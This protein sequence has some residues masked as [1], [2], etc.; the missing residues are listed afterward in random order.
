MVIKPSV[1]HICTALLVAI[2]L[3]GLSAARP[4]AAAE[5]VSG[6]DKLEE[7]IVTANKR[8][9]KAFEVANSITALSSEKLGLLPDFRNFAPLVPGLQLQ[10]ISASRNRLILRGL[11]AGGSGAVVATVIDE[12]PLS[13]STGNAAG[14]VTTTNPLTYDMQRIEVLRG[15]QGTIYG[16]SSEGGLIKYVTNKPELGGWQGGFELGGVSVSGGQTAGSIKGFINLPLG[17]TFALRIT[18]FTEDLPG[19]IDN[20]L[21]GEK[22]MNRGSRK[23]G[24]IGALWQ[25][26][27]NLAISAQVAKQDLEVGASN[28]VALVGAQTQLNAGQAQPTNR[29]D[30]KRGVAYDSAL[31]ERESSPMTY[32]YLQIDYD[33]PFAKITSV[34]SKGTLTLDSRDDF[35][36]RQIRPGIPQYRFFGPG[37]PAPIYRVPLVSDARNEIKLTKK[38]QELRV[39]S[40]P[41]SK[42]GGLDLDWQIGGMVTDEF[43]DWTQSAGFYSAAD[44]NGPELVPPGGNAELD[45]PN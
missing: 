27:E 22:D 13:F 24:R 28:A 10:Q 11:N 1:S 44:P 45:A 21:D 38:T 23:G 34:T 20:I 18:G 3:L 7:V 39:A 25:P 40:L 32:G 43:T 12:M 5:G 35:S 17:E 9:E 36:G 14:A 19:Y 2:A 29:Q 33:A 8:Q 4:A 31:D 6:A 15:P 26:T 30:L 41:D 37:G 42:I 16:A